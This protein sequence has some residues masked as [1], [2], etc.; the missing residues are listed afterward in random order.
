MQQ[1][2][3]VDRVDHIVTET[4]SQ[5]RDQSGLHSLSQVVR[6]FKFCMCGYNSISVFFPVIR[7]KSLFSVREEPNR[8]RNHTPKWTLARKVLTKMWLFPL[9]PLL[10]LIYQ[11]C[12]HPVGPAPSPFFLEEDP[13]PADYSSSIIMSFT[14]CLVLDFSIFY[15]VSINLK[16]GRSEFIL[17]CA[18]SAVCH[19]ESC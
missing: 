6:F 17:R 9:L 14:V 10:I 4:F 11:S 12:V 1:S 15:H 8:R 18:S 16:L 13:F 5:I 2:Q 3:E 7:F 19:W